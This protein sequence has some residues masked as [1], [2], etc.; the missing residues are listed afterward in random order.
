MYKMNLLQFYDGAPSLVVKLEWIFRFPFIPNASTNQ[1][2]V[3]GPTAADRATIF[4]TLHLKIK[5]EYQIAPVTLKRKI[6][7]LKDNYF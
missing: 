4:P 7:G 6:E 3:R 5:S 2:N 1:S